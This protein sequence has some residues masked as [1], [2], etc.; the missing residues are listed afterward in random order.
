M[1]AGHR[2]HAQTVTGH[3]RDRLMDGI[4]IERDEISLL[5]E[6]V[7]AARKQSFHRADFVDHPAFAGL[8]QCRAKHVFGLEG[9]RV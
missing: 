4:R 6:R 3:P 9:N 5:I 7:G 1:T 8:M 2:Q